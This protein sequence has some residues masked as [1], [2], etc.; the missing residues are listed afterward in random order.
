MKLFIFGEVEDI[1]AGVQVLLQELGVELAEDGF[2]VKVE[3]LSGKIEVAS[4]GLQ[5]IIRFDQKIH[6]FRALGLFIEA[7]KS[8]KSFE[9]CEEPQFTKNGVM[10]DASRNAV[11]T[12]DSIKL[13]IRKMALMGL[14]MI[15]LYTEDT[16]TIDGRPYFGYMR[17]RYSKSELRECDD[18]ADRFGIEIIPC[19][20]TLAHLY[21]AL[22]WENDNELKDTED[23]L[24]VGSDRTYEFIEEMIKAAASP[25]RS[26][27]IHIGMDE[28]HNLGLGRYLDVNG[29]RRRF[30]IMTEHLIRVKNIAQKN[31]LK[32]MIWSD[33]YF[34]L[35]SKNGYYYDMEAVIPDDVAAKA[36]KDVDLVYWDYY[37]HDESTYIKMID[38]HKKFGCN[39]IFAGGIWTFNGNEINYEKTFVTT[40]AGLNACKK[41]GVKEVF[42]TIWG[43]N[44][45]E[46]NYFS[47]LLGLQLFAEHGYTRKLDMEK[48]KKRFKFC[49]GGNFDAFMDLTYFD[50]IPSAQKKNTKLIANPSKYILWQ[51]IL[52]GLFDR[53]LTGSDLTK[54]YLALENK[55][56]LHFEEAE[57]WNFV[58]DVPVKHA[59][60]LS[61]KWDIGINIK[62]CYDKRDIDGL[63]YLAEKQLPKLLDRVNALRA[64]HRKQWLMT[65]KPFDWEVIDMRYGGLLS[66]I[67]SAIVR[68]TDFITGKTD[69]IEELEEERLFFN[70]SETLEGDTL[71]RCNMYH[72][73]VSAS[74][75]GFNS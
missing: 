16:Y 22:K 28:A 36:P 4:D 66:R 68:L 37:N 67:D 21:A 73:I 53:D 50:Q 38:K 34:R 51:D 11:M 58:F 12:I 19:I 20:Q 23:I 70:G 71:E 52:L 29:Y 9:I 6:F 25:F 26:K 60:V 31:G 47:S 63:K 24:L 14:N 59:Q 54:H 8:K 61:L 2:P 30:D 44:G 17:G 5:G 7:M 40:N 13:F 46:T 75:L 10:F 18:Y 27:R 42:A 45:A 55:M 15:M 41:E 64:A 33:M 39:I 56:K 69:R 74:P 3:R 49:T 62:A 43:D 1:M 35:A 48:L 57:E 65:Y 72:R 32:P